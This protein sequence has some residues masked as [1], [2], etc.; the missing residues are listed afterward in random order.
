MDHCVQDNE[1][2]VAILQ[3]VLTRVKA[4]DP[5]IEYAYCR[6]DNAGCY[7]SAGTILSLPMIS[8][9]TKIKILRIDFS[10]P[11][12]GK[13]ACDRYAAVIKANVR[14]Y[15]NEKHNITNAAEFVEAIHSYEGVKGVQSYECS[16]IRNPKPTKVTFPKI[17][18]V[19]NFGFEH[20]GLRVH[21][22]WN[23]G[24]GKLLKWPLLDTPKAIGHLQC[25]PC[26]SKLQ[27]SSITTVPKERKS[28]SDRSSITMTTTV[29]PAV[30]A[31]RS[32]LYDCPEEECAASFIRYGNLTQHLC[33]G[34]HRRRIERSSMR[35]MG[36]TMYHSKLENTGVRSMISLQLEE[37][38][39][40]DDDDT[41]RI[42]PDRE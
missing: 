6:A 13:S 2:V 27:L 37:T 35:D 5:S 26:S 31:S 29:E 28:L 3:D 16:L 9:K 18:F 12:A 14:R 33:T 4:D 41:I 24:V 10:D 22:A 32:K 1:S 39:P 40:D 34:K 42:T 30:Q 36:M 20:D 38:T 25:Q 19:N 21:R 17:T 11:Q 7:H 23:V 8:E 15:L